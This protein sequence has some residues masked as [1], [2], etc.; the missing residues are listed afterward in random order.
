MARQLNRSLALLYVDLDQFKRI[1]DTLGHETGDA[2]LRQV[3]ERLRA[4]LDLDA[5]GDEP[6]VPPSIEPIN[7]AAPERVRGQLARVGGDEFIVVLTGRTD[8]EQAQCGGAAD[9][10]DTGRSFSAGEL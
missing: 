9:S 3:A 4:G 10:I 8:V 7:A 1:N 6:A 5:G 2:L